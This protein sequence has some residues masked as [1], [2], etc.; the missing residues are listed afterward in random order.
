MARSKAQSMAALYSTE[1]ATNPNQERRVP[2]D[3]S[4][5][6]R[7]WRPVTKIRKKGL[8]C[9]RTDNHR[10]FSIGIA[11]GLWASRPIAYRLS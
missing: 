10:K 3:F 7:P 4:F 2:C 11:K 6:I 5:C 9:T 8:Q 1:A